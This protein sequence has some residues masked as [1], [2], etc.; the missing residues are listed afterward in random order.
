MVKQNKEKYSQGTI[1][2]ETAIC[3][4][5]HRR[6]NIVFSIPGAPNITKNKLVKKKKSTRQMKANSW[7]IGFLLEYYQ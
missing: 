6:R 4:V 7:L 3:R 5:L 1:H 2:F